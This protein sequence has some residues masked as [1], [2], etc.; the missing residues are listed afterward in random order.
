MR[1]LIF[2]LIAGLCAAP[3][4]FAQEILTSF[5]PLQMI[6]LELTR[7]VSKPDVLLGANAS[8]HDYALRPSDVKRLNRADLVIWFG[9]S[10]EPFLTKVL[11]DKTNVFTLSE[12]PGLELLE[13][14]HA[15]HEH[16]HDDGDEHEEHHDHGRF[17]PHFWMGYTQTLTVAKA[18]SDKL[19][20]LDAAHAEQYQHNFLEF[21]VRLK[22]TFDSIEQ[23]LTPL[24]QQGYYVFHD[25][26]EYFEK[27]HQLNHLGHFT[28][29]PER[30]PGAKTLITI[31]QQ[32]ASSQAKCVFAEPQFTPAVVES[33]VRGTQAKV[34]T[35]DP[36]GTEV[37]LVPG[38]YFVF[39]S[40]MADSFASCLAQ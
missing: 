27:D 13:F 20:E 17:N 6:T 28:V 29:S 36:L 12:I 1:R 3:S 9:S 30:K 4:A 40:N 2:L 33:V 21:S 35:L 5:K 24:R 37:A 38:S 14:D 22:Q 39:L 15:E 25:A 18:I 10:L 23:T 34:G 26:Y 19:A 11:E 31:R 7:G 16:D 32:L 8:P